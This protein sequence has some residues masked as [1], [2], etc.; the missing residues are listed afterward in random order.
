M[1]CKTRAGAKL[2]AR[3]EKLGREH[4]ILLS[5]LAKTT[6]RDKKLETKILAKNVKLLEA[7]FEYVN[8]LYF[9][10]EKQEGVYKSTK[11]NLAGFV[12]ET[13]LELI[14]AKLDQKP[15]KAGK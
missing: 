5:R 2:Y 6:K 10:V 13:Q 11:K 8:A 12:K 15:N 4:D 1:F 14:Q 9:F 7:T 3:S